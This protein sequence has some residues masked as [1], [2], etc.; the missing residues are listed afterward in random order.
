M[1]TT[2]IS[3]GKNNPISQLAFKEN[4]STREID[5]KR[6]F[7]LINSQRNTHEIAEIMGKEIHQISGRF[8]ELKKEWNAK[9]KDIGFSFYKGKRGTIYAKN[10]LF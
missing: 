6:V 1:N 8:T 7:E 2:D 3:R 9:I 4:V 10:E 5:R